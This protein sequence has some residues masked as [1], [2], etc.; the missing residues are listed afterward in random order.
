MKKS[1]ETPPGQPR[2]QQEPSFE[3]KHEKWKKKIKNA[4]LNTI[5]W[6]S[7]AFAQFTA[8]CAQLTLHHEYIAAGAGIA[9]AGAAT[10]AVMDYLKSRNLRK[11][12]EPTKKENQSQP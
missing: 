8:A 1:F 5:L 11:K 9:S 6:S 12:I 7:L 2:E 3:E 10:V 4:E